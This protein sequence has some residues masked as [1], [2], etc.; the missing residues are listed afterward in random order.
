MGGGKTPSVQF[1]QPIEWYGQGIQDI[2]GLGRD[3]TGYV[4]QTPPEQ[5]TENIP[6]LQEMARREATINALNSA[7][8][9]RELAPET[10]RMRAGLRQQ[11]EED[12]AGGPSRELSNLWLRQ[13]LSD[14]VGTGAKTESGFARSALADRSRRDYYANRQALQ[15][16]VSSYLQANPAPVA[17]LDPGSLAGIM[18]QTAAENAN[19]RNAYR[20]QVLGYMGAQT[21]NV[22]NAFNQAAQM[23]AARRAQNVSAYNAAQAAGAANRASMA[24][25]LIGGGGALAGAGITAAGIAL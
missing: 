6:R 13:G 21:G 11:L 10:S 7:A 25:A 12:F 5:L 8:L 22:A 14:V 19:L 23:E 24:G 1:A 16:R 17:G 2:L 4:A 15:D 3:M 18:S 9:E 20:Q